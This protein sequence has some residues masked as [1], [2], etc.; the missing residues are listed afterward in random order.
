LGMARH[1]Y[2]EPSDK[3]RQRRTGRRLRRLPRRMSVV[4]IP[5]APRLA[6]TI[7]IP[8]DKSITHRA[9]LFGALSDRTVRVDR[10]LDSED[11]FATLRAVEACGIT[12]DGLLGK[13]VDIVGRGPN[14][15]GSPP[16][17]DCANSGTLMRLLAGILAGKGGGDTLL[18]GDDS[19]CRRPMNRIAKPLRAMGA[20][21]VTTPGGTPPMAV[22]GA[23]PLRAMEHRLEVASAQVKSCILLAGL[24]A[25]GETWVQEPAASRDHTERMLAAAG[26]EVLHDGPLRVGVRGPVEHL[27]LPDLTVP[28][29]ISSAAFHLVAA[30][31]RADPE[32]RLLG[33]NLNPRRTGIL[34]VMRRMGADVRIE[35][36]PDVAGEPCGDLVVR[37]AGTLHAT[38]IGPDEVPRLID[39]L[40]IVGLLAAFAAG[41]TVVRGAEELRV[42]ESDRISTVVAAL[43]ALGVRAD[44]RPDGFEVTGAPRLVGG[45]VDA[46][47]DHR[48]AMLGA[49]AGLVSTDGVAVSGFEVAAVSY[50]GFTADLAAL[51]AVAP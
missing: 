1:H 14:G 36:G 22:R 9:L 50:P 5:P 31:L 26:V 12:V 3:N 39:E 11:T 47:G 2:N 28:G 21:V 18:D 16:M 33:V 42:K 4:R 24:F 32:V 15:L 7:H 44:E 19:L 29:D 49:I 37:R 45:E 35:P 34:D 6:G 38:E 43:R 27:V 46:H 20:D 10:P 40:P 23:R 30:A 51:G 13:R 8:P 17:V 48:L 25:D 41:T